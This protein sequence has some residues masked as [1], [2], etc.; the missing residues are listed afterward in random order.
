MNPHTALATLYL[1]LA[2]ALMVWATVQNGRERR[3]YEL[4]LAREGGER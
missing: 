3:R 4:A 1:T 2:V